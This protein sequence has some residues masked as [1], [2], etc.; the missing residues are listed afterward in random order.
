MESILLSIDIGSSQ[1]KI[2]Y[3]LQ[4][5]KVIGFL[6]MPP[7]V[8]EISQSRLDNFF[9]RRGWIGNPSLEQQLVISC[10]ERLVVLGEFA[11]SFD[12]ISRLKELKYENALWK[13]L[14]AIGLIV[15][16]SETK[17]RRSKQ[18]KLKLAVLLPWNEYNDRHR[19][20]EQL[21]T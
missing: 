10:G 18:V 6:V 17:I 20:R 16:K 1:T 11:S 2:I 15:H 14:G 21:E 13:V 9:E 3:Q 7:E 5:K 8:E 4:K 19:F 12:P